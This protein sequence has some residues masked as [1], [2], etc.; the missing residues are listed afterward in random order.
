MVRVVIRQNIVP[1]NINFLDKM[2]SFT[3]KKTTNKQTK[4]KKKTLVYSSIKI[5]RTNS[6]FNDL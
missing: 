6:V 4:N 5:M 2:M 1:R 3:E